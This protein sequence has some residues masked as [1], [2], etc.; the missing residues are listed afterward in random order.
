M[1]VENVGLFVYVCVSG[2]LLV[3]EIQTVN[4]KQTEKKEAKLIW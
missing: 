4:E 3:N 1:D 2:E